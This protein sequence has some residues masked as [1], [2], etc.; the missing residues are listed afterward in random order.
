MNCIE[1]SGVSANFVAPVEL[2]DKGVGVGNGRLLPANYGTSLPRPREHS[3]IIL[4]KRH[5][6][7]LPGV[8]VCHYRVL[9]GLGRDF[10][11]K[12]KLVTAPVEA[13]DVRSL[14]NFR[15]GVA[16]EVQVFPIL[17]KH[18]HADFRK[19]GANGATIERVFPMTDGMSDGPTTSYGTKE[20][21][22]ESGTSIISG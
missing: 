18:A 1:L 21:G 5:R 19:S 9:S 8:G 2:A 7:D 14:R 11:G 12:Q 15:G 17:R 3:G 4:P 10:G 22:T 13:L 20:S 16:R 6:Y